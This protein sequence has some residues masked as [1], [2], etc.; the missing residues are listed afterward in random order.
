MSLTMLAWGV[1]GLVAYPFGALADRIGERE[2]LATMA[3]GVLVIV[4]AAWLAGIPL[5]E[6]AGASA[7][8]EAL[9]QPAGGD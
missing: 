1:N 6:G 9:P 7:A 8:P 2:T 4:G 5:K 3:A